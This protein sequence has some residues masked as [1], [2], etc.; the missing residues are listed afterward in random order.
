MITV[1]L[2]RWS[3]TQS[4]QQQK[5][6]ALFRAAG[7]SAPP[8]FFLVEEE[9]PNDS[10]WDGFVSEAVE[11]LAYRHESGRILAYSAYELGTSLEAF[12]ERVS[13]ILVHGLSIEIVREGSELFGG[14][15]GARPLIA[16]SNGGRF[17]S[18]DFENVA[19]LYRSIRRERIKAA[20]DAAKLEGK[21]SARVHLPD[22]TRDGIR[23]ALNHGRE[24]LRAI[25]KRHD[26]SLRTVQRIRDEHH[27]GS[28]AAQPHRSPSDVLWELQAHVQHPEEHLSLRRDD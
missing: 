19:A 16:G 2:A 8:D 5:H 11:T 6:D 4:E 10:R 24:S 3:K 20:E 9:K 22:A 15:P 14:E 26:V 7:A 1:G 17:L 12:A 23:E 28:P 21:P 27:A 25:A 18:R 13:Q